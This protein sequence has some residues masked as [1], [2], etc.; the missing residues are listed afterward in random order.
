MV[1]SPSAEGG[2]LE[3]L[4][5]PNPPPPP[6]HTYIQNRILNVRRIGVEVLERKD[7]KGRGGELD[8]WIG[9]GKNLGRRG[10]G[11]GED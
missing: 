9:C 2:Q 3:S 6:T 4:Q 7:G 1:E 10:T 8:D 11:G 5:N